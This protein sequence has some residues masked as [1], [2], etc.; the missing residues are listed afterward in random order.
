MAPNTLVVDV[1]RKGLHSVEPAV[2]A[3][4]TVGPF[5][6]ELRNHGRAAHV[7]CNVD[8]ALSRVARLSETNHYVETES[9]TRFRVD[10]TD[11]PRPVSGR[12]KFV[13]AY[14]AEEAELPMTVR[15]P[16]N[17]PA[18][19]QQRDGAASPPATDDDDDGR[20]GIGGVDV[21]RFSAGRVTD[22]FPD[23]NDA[24]VLGLAGVALLVAL[25]ATV[26]ADSTVVTLGVASVLVGVVVAMVVLI[27]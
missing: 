5:H 26:V 15:D 24:P 1:S 8:D 10:V 22:L 6:V 3:F 9:T 17:S 19:A 2:E 11:G 16:A 20:F 12:L 27:R 4:D 23:R 21:D 7:H 25:A 18:V 14:G 13:T